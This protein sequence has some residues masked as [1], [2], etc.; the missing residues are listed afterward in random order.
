MR[1]PRSR[2][3]RCVDWRRCWGRPQRNMR[4]RIPTA[5]DEASLIRAAEWGG[6]IRLATDE[7]FMSSTPLTALSRAARADQPILADK[8][9]MSGDNPARQRTALWQE[10]IGRR[11]GHR[12][13]PWPAAPRHDE[14]VSS[15]R[16]ADEAL[17]LDSEQ[18]VCSQFRPKQSIMDSL[19][20]GAEAVADHWAQLSPAFQARKGVLAYATAT[21]RIGSVT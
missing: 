21:H 17:H 20:L 8:F 10:S 16:P 3:D 18:V 4:A 12:L 6:R 14:C 2:R 19:P 11:S 5:H 9:R 13:R 1:V 15:R 7:P